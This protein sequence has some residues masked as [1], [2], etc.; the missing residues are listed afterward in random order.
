MD[1]VEPYQHL[2]DHRRLRNR[3]HQRNFRERE[4]QKKAD[5]AA[6]LKRLSDEIENMRNSQQSSAER[7]CSSQSS[8]PTRVREIT[9]PMQ[10]PTQVPMYHPFTP[11]PDGNHSAT[12]D[13]PGESFGRTSPKTL[14]LGNPEVKLN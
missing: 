2:A 13:Q 11:L 8:T 14:L 6:E 5:Q 7:P 12:A 9:T 1:P 4:A 10:P 3:E